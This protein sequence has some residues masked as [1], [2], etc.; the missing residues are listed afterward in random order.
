MRIS[1]VNI[2][3]QQKAGIENNNIYYS[4]NKVF[5]RSPQYDTI[6]FTGKNTIMTGKEFKKLS[7][8]MTC[9]YTGEQMLTSHQLTKM[10]RR[11]FFKGPISEVVRKLKPYENKYLEP[12]EKE[13][14][15]RI[16]Q[17]SKET[18][19]IDLPQLFKNWY[20][21]TRANFRRTQKPNFDAIKTLGAQLPQEYLEPFFKFME[22]VDKKLYDKPVKQEFNL[23][24][25]TYKINKITEKMSDLSLKNRIEKLMGM[26]HSEYFSNNKKPLP[27]T[28]VKEVFNFKNLKVPGRKNAYYEKYL[29]QYEKH[30][31]SVRIQII[32]QMRDIAGLKGYKKLQKLCESNIDMIEG[33]PVHIPFSNKAFIYDLDKFLTNMP[34]AELKQK[35]LEIAQNL[36][37]S[38]KSADALILKFRDADPDIIGDRLFNPAL[39]SIE[40]LKP[41]SENGAS[42]IH[43]CALAKRYINSER[44][45]RPLWQIL[46]NYPLKNQQKYVNNLAKLV[47]RG[48]VKYEDAL[49]Q[50]ETIEQEGHIKLNKS[51]L[52][53]PDI[54]LTEQIKQK[55]FLNV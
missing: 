16:E 51:K 11:G 34:D 13:V 33:K 29:K 38:A 44:Q 39:A 17:A 3:R 42:T 55:L 35:M 1:P 45:S 7:R 2:F 40:H 52:K 32:G 14:F 15:Q 37:T 5:I 31:D 53:Q 46:L 21:E 47:E 23:K 25:F 41:A 9:L 8:Y 48:K 43:N 6:N 12:I 28:L 10:K 4:P 49:I 22:T 36:P 54:R 19:D 18:P 26:L 20:K 50:I 30:K 24:E 27:S